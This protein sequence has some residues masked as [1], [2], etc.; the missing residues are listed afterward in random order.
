MSRRRTRPSIVVAMAAAAALAGC[1]P[2]VGSDPTP[3]AM[4]VDLTAM[5]PRAPKPTALI[6]N[7]QTGLIDFGL[8]GTPIP[9]DC[10]MQQAL[11][12][13]QCQFNQ[14]LETLNGFPT[15][16]PASAP[17][18]APLDPAT[19]TLGANVV[20]VAAKQGVAMTDLAVDFDTT[21]SS[22]TPR[23]YVTR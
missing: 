22:L 3:T 19:L 4:Q 11:T 18:S 6:V 1:L 5:P 8:A 13:A 14:W 21:S 7:Q 15:V 12:E 20:A 16:T 23:K 17:A 9:D 10:S 2:D